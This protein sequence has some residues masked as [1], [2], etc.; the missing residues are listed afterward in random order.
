M[1]LLH[2]IRIMSTIILTNFSS[3]SIKM[4]YI[5]KTKY[6]KYTR[7]MLLIIDI[8]LANRQKIGLYMGDSSLLDRNEVVLNF[9]FKDMIMRPWHN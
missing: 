2:I 3:N 5:S 6:L 8:S 1:I 9:P 7:T 4:N